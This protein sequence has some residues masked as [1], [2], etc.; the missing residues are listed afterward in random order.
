MLVTSKELLQ[1]AKKHHFAVPATNFVN[2]ESARAYV[3]TAE[4]LGLP[5]ILAFAQ[6]HMDMIS[7]EEAAL[8]GK[9]YAE[10]SS[11]SVILHLDHGQDF[12]TIEKAIQL[13]FNSVMID[14]S[15][16]PFEENISL[17]KR[18]VEMAHSYG[19]DVESEIGH[20]GSGTNYENHDLSDS[21]YT[22]VED[23]AR[24]VKETNTDTLAVSI[25]TAH[26]FY[27]G[28]PVISFDRLH[29]ISKEV[30]V[31]LVL[32]GG[33]SSGDNNLHRCATEG[34]SKINI[35]TDFMVAAVNQDKKVEL[36]A[37]SKEAEKNMSET[38]EHYF[39]VFATKE[40][41]R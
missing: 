39:N 37:F 19:V 21:I 36:T 5:L 31:P 8:I 15:T 23:A 20:V 41:K 34:I 12:D 24:F 7:L 14:A 28:T 32:H 6:A 38:L 13:G 17:T 1:Y 29:E 35:F 22:E 30:D 27:Q 33:S 18:V 26:G 3:K 10:N 9:Y 16:M 25:G 4:K 2:L 40:Y 11:T